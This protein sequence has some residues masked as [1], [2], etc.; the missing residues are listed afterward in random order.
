MDTRILSNGLSREI[1]P[2]LIQSCEEISLEIGETMFIFDKRDSLDD[3]YKKSVSDERDFKIDLIVDDGLYVGSSAEFSS[4]ISRWSYY[5]TITKTNNQSLR[6]HKAY[7]FITEEIGIFEKKSILDPSKEVI[8]S[9]GGIKLIL[10]P[11]LISEVLYIYDED[12]K[13]SCGVRF[14][15]PIWIKECIS[16]IPESVRRESKLDIILGND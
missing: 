10:K 11:N 9:R 5:D 15:D 1:D 3:F 4:S 14:F 12:R 8:F 16:N 13:I 6:Y 7:K 2:K